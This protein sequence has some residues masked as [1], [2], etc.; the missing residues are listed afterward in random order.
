MDIVTIYCGRTPC[1]R[2][3]WNFCN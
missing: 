3:D 2:V 1:E